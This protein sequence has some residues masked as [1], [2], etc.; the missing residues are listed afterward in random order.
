MLIRFI[1]IFLCITPLLNANSEK[2]KV[3]LNMIVKDEEFTITRCLNSLTHLID[4]WVIVD[5]GSQ[6][7]TKNVITNYFKE[8]KIPGELHEKTFVNF[9]VNRNHAYELAK[10]K[11]DYT[12]FIDADE[13]VESENDFILPELDK[14]YY[15]III[16]HSGSEYTRKFLVNN[17]L[18]WKWTGVLHEYIHANN[19]FNKATLKGIQQIYTYDGVRSRDQKKYI[20][21]CEVLK[22]ALIDEPNNSRYMFYLAQSYKDAG[23]SENALASYQKFLEFGTWDQEIYWSLLWIAILKDKLNYSKD[24]II[25][26]YQKAFFFRP[27]RTEALYYLSCFY[28]KINDHNRSYQIG[29][30]ANSISPSEDILFVNRWI[31]NIGLKIELALSAYWTGNLLESEKICNQ[32]LKDNK[33]LAPSSEEC[34]LNIL[35]FIRQKK[36]NSFPITPTS[37]PPK[38]LAIITYPTSSSSFQWDSNS[39]SKGISGSEESVIYLS[40]ELSSLGYI[41]T[42]YGNPPQN[43]KHTAKN[44]NPRYVS[45][46]SINEIENDYDIAIVWRM[47]HLCKELKNKAKSL[48]LWPHDTLHTAVNDENIEVLTDVFWLTNWQRRQWGNFNP[49]FLNFSNIYGNGI[50]EENCKEVKKKN[51]PY[52]C[53]YASNYGRGLEILLDIWPKIINEYPEASLDIYYGWETWGTLSNEQITTLKQKIND[54]NHLNVREH[55]KVS[56]QKLTEAFHSSSI[57]AYPCTYPETFCITALRA[58]SAGVYPVIIKHS[59]L[60]EVVEDGMW[61][62]NKEDYLNTLL[63]AM[64]FI[65]NYTL[66]NRR[67]LSKKINQ[68]FLWKNIAQ[69]WQMSRGFQQLNSTNEGS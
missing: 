64:K 18:E 15:N 66:E 53:I 54:L 19:A 32:L 33:A 3:C 35:K 50:P 58:Q 22:K 2:P 38:K 30:L 16:K 40:K 57:W 60:K 11:A 47:P 31:E 1:F 20:R 51:N 68:N 4:Y 21:D 17:T 43:S 45:Y 61:C 63:E 14:D 10:S 52:S 56:H 65:P 27:S 44:C 67:N 42:I 26:S 28:R 49:S 6:D 25:N 24:D 12:L 9:E 55:G 69:L 39:I 29:K 8:K 48:Y 36:N 5:T 23:D 34:V 37:D 13:Y 41:V 46:S 62:Q 59:G 7:N